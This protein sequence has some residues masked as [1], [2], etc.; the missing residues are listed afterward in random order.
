MK[1]LTLLGCLLLALQ[2][3]SSQVIDVHLHS[4]TSDEYRGG[5]SL[6]GIAS[7]KT[8]DLHLKETIEEMNKNNIK[9][10]VS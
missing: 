7:P 9:F 1:T 2:P 6:N 3:G 4:Y 8:G 10:A 5:S